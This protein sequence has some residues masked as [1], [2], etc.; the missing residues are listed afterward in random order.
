MMGAKPFDTSKHPNQVLLARP[1]LFT[2]ASLMHMACITGFKFPMPRP[3]KTAATII[4][5]NELPKEI[6]SRLTMIQALQGTINTDALVLSI[7]FDIN[8]RVINL[9]LIHI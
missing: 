9:S 7:R 2:G 1:R 8:N 3:N 4:M 6:K 5:A